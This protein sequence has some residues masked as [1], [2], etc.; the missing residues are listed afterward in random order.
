MIR[1]ILLILHICL[2]TFFALI[3]LLISGLINPYSKFNHLLFQTW[4]DIICKICGLEFEIEAFENFNP[5]K[6]YIVCVNHRN[7][8]DIPIVGAATG[9]NIKFAAKKELFSIPVFGQVLFLIG[10]VKIDRANRQKALDSLKD[11]QKMFTHGVSLVIFPEGTRNRS[12]K[13]LLSFKKGAFV[14][15]VQS[16]QEILPISVND[17]NKIISG[18]S[19][20]PRKIKIVIHPPLDPKAF[21]DNKEELLTIC[22]EKILSGLME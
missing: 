22:Q 6:G 1:A 17:S 2:Y 10:M 12:G 8:L 18:F 5:H 16:G 4:A 7:L 13:G 11:S 21:K 15:A 9:L 14:M 20:K 3:V 19:V